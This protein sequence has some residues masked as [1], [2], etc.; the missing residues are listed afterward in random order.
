MK[1]KQTAPIETEEIYLLRLGK[2]LLNYF[3]TPQVQDILDDYQTHFSSGREHGGST[4]ALI[5]ALGTP[6]SVVAALLQETPEGRT[7]CLRHTACWGALLGVFCVL[8]LR[9]TFRDVWDACLLLTLGSLALFALLHGRGRRALERRF[10]PVPPPHGLCLPP[11]VLVAALEALV[12]SM[13]RSYQNGTA[14]PFVPS[15]PVSVGRWTDGMMCLGIG[16][17][18]GLLIWALW[19]TMARSIQYYPCVLCA[20]GAILSIQGIRT[21]LHGMDMETYPSSLTF[22]ACLAPCGVGLLLA[23]LFGRYIR[24]R[25]CGPW[26]HS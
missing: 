17:L 15:W 23:L 8:L 1:S 11:L 14:Q 22:L 6:A 19:R 4:P 5:A 2:R 16:L 12:L 18:A 7:Y 25:R 9:T 24:G 3:P 26:T 13:L 10:Q 21:I 20:A